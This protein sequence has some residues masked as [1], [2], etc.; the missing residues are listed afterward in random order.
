MPIDKQKI[1]NTTADEAI[2][3]LHI[4]ERDLELGKQ[5]QHA[6][7]LPAL[8]PCCDVMN[9]GFPDSESAN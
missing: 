3:W 5:A 6:F 2:A 4:M 1:F 7:S 8:L 9:W